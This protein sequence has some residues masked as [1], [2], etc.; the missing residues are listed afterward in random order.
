[1]SG[2]PPDNQYVDSRSVR[3]RK[4]FLVFRGCL[5]SYHE[6][7]LLTER[8]GSLRHSLYIHKCL[9]SRPLCRRHLSSK[10]ICSLDL[11]IYSCLVSELYKEVAI[12]NRG[13]EATRNVV[14]GDPPSNDDPPICTVITAAHNTVLTR[15]DRV[16]WPYHTCT[17]PYCCNCAAVN[18]NS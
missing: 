15:G 10:D 8:L 9:T 14:N 1:M 3:I 16:L 17:V 5:Q 11:L 7:V 2:L 6:N 13:T 18:K 12:Q 4:C